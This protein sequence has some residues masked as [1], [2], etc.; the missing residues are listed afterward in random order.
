LP[1]SPPQIIDDDDDIRRFK[2]NISIA[3]IGKSRTVGKN[4]I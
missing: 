4:S 3:K 2:N 1:H